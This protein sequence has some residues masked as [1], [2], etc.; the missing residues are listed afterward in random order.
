MS[1]WVVDHLY[2][3]IRNWVSVLLHTAHQIRQL[4]HRF[5]RNR[6]AIM[7]HQLI[8]N[9]VA[10]LLHTVHWIRYSKPLIGILPAIQLQKVHWI[11]NSIRV[12]VVLPIVHQILR[13]IILLMTD[14][15]L[16]FSNLTFLLQML[17]MFL[18]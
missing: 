4:L 10:V 11:V 14:Q 15:A 17:V 6:V 8:P 13:L 2:Q 16:L 7:Q 3:L 18:Y 5:I 1:N 12:D 9:R